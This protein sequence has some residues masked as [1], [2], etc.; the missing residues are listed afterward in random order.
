M[1]L[2]DCAKK[3]RGGAGAGLSD[4]GGFGLDCGLD[5]DVEP[6]PCS[7]ADGAPGLLVRKWKSCRVDRLALHS[8]FP[9]G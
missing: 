3:G 5:M 1:M 9:S 4:L 2:D 8:V 6:D 7:E